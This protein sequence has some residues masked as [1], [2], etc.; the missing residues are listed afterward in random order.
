MTEEKDD[1]T[2]NYKLKIVSISPNYHKCLELPNKI[3]TVKEIDGGLYK[4]DKVLEDTLKT[5][6]LVYEDRTRGWFLD[7]AR[8]LSS[9]RHAGFLVLMICVSYLEGNQQFRE[10]TVSKM[11][12]NKEMLKKALKRIFNFQEDQE[13]AID[14]FIEEVRHGFFHDGMTR[15]NVLITGDIS[16]PFFINEN[17]KVILLNPKLFL[18]AIEIDFETYLNILR[19]EHNKQEREKFQNY[20][21]ERY[22]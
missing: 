3:V 19:N 21:K 18:E 20:W 22:S 12:E 11:G 14:I 2:I 4:I 15:K 8:K 1:K 7:F 5:K 10:G 17:K 13:S 6:I 9:E 16:Y